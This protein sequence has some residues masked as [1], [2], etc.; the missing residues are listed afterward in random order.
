MAI[1]KNGRDHSATSAGVPDVEHFLYGGMVLNLLLKLLDGK[2][3]NFLKLPFRWTGDQEMVEDQKLTEHF[4]LYNLTYTSHI[5]FQNL[6]RQINDAQIAKLKEVAVKLEVVRVIL[7]CELT[8]TSGYRCMGL[9]TAIG[10]TP[11]SQ[12]VKCE[13]ADFIP[14]DRDIDEC[15]HALISQGKDGQLTFGQ[16]INENGGGKRWLHISLAE[17]YRPPE[18]CGEILTMVDGKYTM[19][20]KVRV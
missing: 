7:G 5:E 13:A 20:D 11:L 1:E 17:P 16:L 4:S 6:N 18:K 10:A 14:Q 12:H 3:L 8:V 19:L 15:F 9:N 2:I